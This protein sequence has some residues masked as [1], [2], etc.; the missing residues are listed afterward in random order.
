MDREE[1]YSVEMPD[2]VL[3]FPPV[4]SKDKLEFDTGFARLTIYHPI[5]A[6]AWKFFLLV[7]RYGSLGRKE[8]KFVQ[9]SI[10]LLRLQS[11]LRTR[12]YKEL[13]DS[14]VKLASCLYFAKLKTEK[15]DYQ[16]NLLY[17]SEARLDDNLLIMWLDRRFVDLIEDRGLW[18]YFVFAHFL[19][20]PSSLNLHAF[21]SANTTLNKPQIATLLER[22]NINISYKPMARKHLEL[23]LGELVSIGFLKGF[24]I[25]TETEQVK[26]FR[27]DHTTLQA[28]AL[29]LKRILERKAQEFLQKTREVKRESQRKRRER[30]KKSLDEFLD[31]FPF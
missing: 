3:R 6:L 28:R 21:L 12:N 2:I 11:L 7:L 15:R 19:K 17:S 23:A 25:D 31:D 30:K 9:V 14:R 10:E 16:F 27:Y 29:E 20:R 4:S 8:E 5:D 13:I 24:E 26:L 18:F 22:A 1:F